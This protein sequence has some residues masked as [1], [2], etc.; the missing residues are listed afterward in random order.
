MDGSNP[1]TSGTRIT[2]SSPFIIGASEGTYQLKCV[3]HNSIG[4]SDVDKETYTL[5]GGASIQLS[6]L[7]YKGHI[8]TITHY[9]GTKEVINNVKKAVENV[10]KKNILITLS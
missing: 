4:Y 6:Y 2:Y 8:L 5:I 1:K 9:D 3:A 7:D 10:K